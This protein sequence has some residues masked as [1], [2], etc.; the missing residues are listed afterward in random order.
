M[1]SRQ[2]IGSTELREMLPSM[3]LSVTYV[4]ESKL[5]INDSL[6]CFN[7]LSVELWCLSAVMFLRV[8]DLVFCK[9]LFD[10]KYYIL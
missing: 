3:L 5:S 2:P 9:T 6:D 4:R 10:N 7:Q 1:I 8:F